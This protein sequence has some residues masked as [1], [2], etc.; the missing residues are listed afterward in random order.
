M[1][2]AATSVELVNGESLAIYKDDKDLKSNHD[3]VNSD[4]E[5]VST[6]LARMNC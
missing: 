4:E 6:Q 3:T 1:A 2:V 5:E